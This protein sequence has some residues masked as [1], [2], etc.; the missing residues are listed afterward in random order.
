MTSI[1]REKTR[2]QRYQEKVQSGVTKTLPLHIGCINF[3]KEPNVAHAYRTAACFGA[4]ELNLVGSCHLDHSV[5]RAVSGT[6]TGLTPLRQHANAAE[7][8]E[9]S[10]ENNLKIIALEMPEESFGLKV[11]NFYEYEFNFSFEQ[12]Y[13]IITGG[14]SIGIMYEIL[15]NSEILTIPCFGASYCLNT[16]QVLN[17]AVNEFNRQYYNY[18]KRIDNV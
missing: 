4:K 10:R 13:I 11:S 14:E 6:T 18:L 3:G 2:M 16:S 7:F 1:V 8:V 17:M 12:N 15:K 5:M 9:F